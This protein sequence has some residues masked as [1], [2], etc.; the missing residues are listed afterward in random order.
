MKISKHKIAAVLALFIGI[1][2]VFAGLR[3][4]LGI[5][6]PDYS[7]L[8]WLVQYNVVVGAISIIV[9]FLIWTK[10]YLS[11]AAALIIFVA[12]SIVLVLLV[13]VFNEVAAVES[14]KAMGF[15]TTIWIIIVILNFKT[16]KNEI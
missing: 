10:N 15:R 11:K 3:V 7:I 12:H 5:S 2:S 14:M 1:M 9:T 13:S 16:F 8:Q 6:T 4:L